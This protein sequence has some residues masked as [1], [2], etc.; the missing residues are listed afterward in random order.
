MDYNIEMRD[1]LRISSST[2]ELGLLLAMML[3]KANQLSKEESFDKDYMETADPRL[4][5]KINSFTEEWK[6]MEGRVEAIIE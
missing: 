1:V 4:V 3:L 6:T 5:N 2:T